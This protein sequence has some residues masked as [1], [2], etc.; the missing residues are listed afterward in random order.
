MPLLLDDPIA[1]ESVNLFAK[2][3]T[4]SRQRL[5][6]EIQNIRHEL[7]RRKSCSVQKHSVSGKENRFRSP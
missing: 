6:V 3:L 7:T 1:P 2:D 5:T 4:L